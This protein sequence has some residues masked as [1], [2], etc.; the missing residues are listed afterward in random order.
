M[1]M[2]A[3][4][5]AN[6]VYSNTDQST[7]GVSSNHCSVEKPWQ[8]ASRSTSGNAG[9]L[10]WQWGDRLSSGQTSNDGNTIYHGSSD[11]QCLVTDHVKAIG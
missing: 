5:R 6:R 3:S 10:F 8:V 7:D 2:L 11:F 9:D 4:Q 1:P